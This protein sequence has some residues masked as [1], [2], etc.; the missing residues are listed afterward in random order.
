MLIFIFL[1]IGAGQNVAL[2][3]TAAALFYIAVLYAAAHW[4]CYLF[5]LVGSQPVSKVPQG[6]PE[7]SGLRLFRHGRILGVLLSRCCPLLLSVRDNKQKHWEEINEPGLILTGQAAGCYPGA[8]ALLAAHIFLRL[9]ILFLLT[10][11]VVDEAELEIHLCVQAGAEN[12][13]NSF[14]KIVKV[15]L[16]LGKNSRITL[17][18]LHMDWTVELHRL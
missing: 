13:P 15:D 7:A 14:I 9:F 5:S 10:F 11:T 18:T 6:V 16:F 3:Y 1:P 2:W 17:K 8:A 12:S 4:S